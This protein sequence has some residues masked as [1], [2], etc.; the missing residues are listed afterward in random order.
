MKV[1]GA[2]FPGVDDLR[3]YDGDLSLVPE[4]ARMLEAAGYDG[5][6]TIET[7]IDPFFNLLLAA[8]HT[9]RIELITGVAIAFARSPMT[10][11]LQAWNLQQYSKGRFILGLGSQIQTHIER[12]FSMPW[13]GPAKQ[14]REYVLA[15]RSIWDSWATG[16]KLN[17]RGEFY[18]HTIT[19]P[20]FTPAPIDGP[21]P[22]IHV[23][24]LGPRMV[25]MAG[26]VA[27]GLFGHP[28]NTPTFIHEVQMPA[29]Q[30]GLAK[31]GRTLADFEMPAMVITITG[32]TEEEMQAAEANCRRLLAFY[33]TTPAYWRVMEAHGWG[34]LGPVLNS[35]SKENRWAE[36]PDLL[37]DEM[38]AELC[39]KG[40]PEDIP[41]LIDARVGSFADRLTLYAPYAS[42]P[43]MWEGI[44]R[45]I[46]ALPG[47]T[48]AVG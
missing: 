39:V 22:K 30:R 4:R 47:K 43:A 29:L 36:M 18:T 35:M 9:E 41:A 15:L 3:L 21:P 12:R 13:H 24:A 26:E 10:V 45:G 6:Y 48:A 42:D 33:G 46:K 8:E 7:N 28:F 37:P 34:D 32:R 17:F 14:M 1:D 11:A 44:V 23:G 16:S 5:L 20:V 19:N 38:V 31:S 40:A 25:E 2:L 27:D